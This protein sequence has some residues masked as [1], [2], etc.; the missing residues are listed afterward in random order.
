M[1][2]EVLNVPILSTNKTR[3]KEIMHSGLRQTQLELYIRQFEGI[4]SRKA[5]N[6]EM[7]PRDII[8]DKYGN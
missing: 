2:H 1:F 6:C 5:N 4:L 3:M 7:K 8:C